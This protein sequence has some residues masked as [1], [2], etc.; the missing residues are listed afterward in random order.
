MS[1]IR[2]AA[3]LLLVL[4]LPLAGCAAT[5]S[6]RGAAVACAPCGEWRLA[7]ADDAAAAIDAALQRYKPPR[8]RRPRAAY[9][10]IQ[11][12][13]EAELQ[14][15][16]DR[17]PAQ[18]RQELREELEKL[19]PAPAGLRLRQDG[20][21][22]VIEPAAG[23]SRRLTPGEPHSRVDA[24]GTARIVGRW[25]HNGLEVVDDYDRRGTSNR[26]SYLVDPASGH[27]RVTRSFERRG[28]PD[29]VL[30][31][32]YVPATPAH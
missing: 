7:S 16:L 26:E 23:P 27:L 13:S 22:L 19:V 21:D 1:P 12:E 32:E 8:F 31:S 25:R 18:Y 24:L 3:A 5:T 20:E 28:M 14:A 15:S 17:P 4:A 11:A 30:H 9:G 2:A 6:A 10:D 29:L